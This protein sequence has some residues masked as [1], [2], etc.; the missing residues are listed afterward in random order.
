MEQ[1][2]PFQLFSLILTE[3]PS[4][5]M[6]SKDRC[7]PLGRKTSCLLG[8]Q[9]RRYPAASQGCSD[10]F[11]RQWSHQ[12][13]RFLLSYLRQFWIRKLDLLIERKKKKQL[14]GEAEWQQFQHMVPRQNSQATWQHVHSDQSVRKRKLVAIWDDRAQ[15]SRASTG[16][17]GERLV[18]TPWAAS[19]K[20]V[21][22]KPSTS[23]SLH[24]Y[25]GPNSRSFLLSWF[26]S[27][28]WI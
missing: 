15:N 22:V 16:R 25:C 17:A 12:Q 5:N 27:V 10:C 7:Y 9:S 14:A 21:E 20:P 19:P 1:W 28:W 4:K 26:E 3:L 11:R 24:S 2:F 23:V 18:H 6:D 13:S 8:A